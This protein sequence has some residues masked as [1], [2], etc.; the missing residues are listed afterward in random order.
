MKTNA[1]GVAL[2]KRFESLQL[3]SYLCPA[4]I[5]TI[6]Y[7]HVGPETK[8][9]QSI[10]EHAANVI[11]ELDLERFEEGVESALSGLNENQFSACVSLAFN[12]GLKA[13]R[14]SSVVRR[15]RK[16]DVPGAADAFLL[17]NK[18]RIH[19]VHEVLPG[20]VARRQAERELF[21]TPVTQKE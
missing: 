17:W 5:P 12:I 10:T 8:L 9:G 14:P 18:A 20:L 4:G 1:A 15:W 6:G 3:N 11:L 7:G 16:G 21:L 2:I 13:F 19:G